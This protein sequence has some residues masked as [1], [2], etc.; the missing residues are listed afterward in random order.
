MVVLEAPVPP[1]ES[2]RNS[3]M[4]ACYLI[5]SQLRWLGI[6]A[7]R[8]LDLLKLKHLFISE[9]HHDMDLV[10]LG[11]YHR[12]FQGN[13]ENPDRETLLNVLIWTQAFV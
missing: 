12:D 10:V 8:R 11:G 9:A 13:G 7:I 4:Q 3:E 1:L 2:E 6:T 5:R